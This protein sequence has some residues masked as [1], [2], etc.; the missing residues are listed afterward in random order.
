MLRWEG[1]GLCVQVTVCV[2]CYEGHR[3]KREVADSHFSALI[4]V[5]SE[6]NSCIGPLHLKT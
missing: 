5:E 1:G 2:F 4:H 6:L 3:D